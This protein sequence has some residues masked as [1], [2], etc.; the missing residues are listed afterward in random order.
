MGTPAPKTTEPIPAPKKGGV[1]AAPAMIVVNVPV[2]ATI[3]IDGTPTK[4]TSAVRVFATPRLAP[5]SVYYY[6]VTAQ[7]VRDGK[8]LTATE[9]IAV[10]AGPT[11]SFSLNPTQAPVVASK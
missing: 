3:T 4:S 7:V 10:E 2:D 5:G 9:K 1:T 8:T 11:R 6:N